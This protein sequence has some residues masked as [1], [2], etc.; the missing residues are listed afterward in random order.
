[1]WPIFLAKKYTDFFNEEQSAACESYQLVLS[2]NASVPISKTLSYRRP[3]RCTK[4]SHYEMGY[5][6]PMEL[7]LGSEPNIKYI[8]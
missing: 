1:M 2:S 6:D 3:T 5:F 8:S 4:H 7:D